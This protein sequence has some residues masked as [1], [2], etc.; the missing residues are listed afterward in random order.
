MAKIRK[1][2]SV[3]V[4]TGKDRGKI[5]RVIKIMDK[6]Q[7]VIVEKVNTVKRHTRPTQKNPQGGI[8]EKELSIHI[9]NV[10]I[11]DPKSGEKSRVGFKNLKDGQKI[12]I[13]K[14]S[15]EVVGAK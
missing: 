9:S 4:T 14:K 12:R 10:M 8:M 2:D 6:G 11:V 13:S 3:M 15:G 5:G 7:R 1:D